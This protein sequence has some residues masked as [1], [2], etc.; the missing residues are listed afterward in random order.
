MKSRDGA[1]DRSAH[2]ASGGL[3]PGVGE[4]R[5]GTPVSV[6]DS[7]L[8]A[9]AAAVR[10]LGKYA[11]D[12]EQTPRASFAKRC[13]AWATHLLRGTPPP[14]SPMD[15]GPALPAASRRAWG[16]LRRFLVDRRREEQRFVEGHLGNFKTAVSDLIRG[17]KAAMH[18]D[19]GVD[20][21]IISQL[22][23]LEQ[24]VE[25][26]EL[27]SLST[28]VPAAVST[29]RGELQRRRTTVRERLAAMGKRL[30]T[31]KGDLAA[32]RRDAEIDDLTKVYNRAAF[33]RVFQQVMRLS[34]ASAEPVVLAVIDL[35][36]FKHVN[37]TWGH[38][39]GDTVLRA[40]ADTIVRTFPRKN[41]FVAR[42]GGEEFIVLLRD[43]DGPTARMLCDRLLQRIR[44]LEV[45]VDH[46]TIRVTCSVGFTCALPDDTAKEFL[47]RA[48]RA[49]YRAKHAGR[50]QAI[51]G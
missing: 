38:P 30:A 26:G 8:D 13:E 4:G 1:V 51:G 34:V 33:S 45:L 23:R 36:H 17:L 2:E 6:G 5:Y 3:E 22:A 48:D 10:T 25:S 42:Y 32:T 49:L 20:S 31:L 39:A 44:E 18:E 19:E 37:D 9:L 24:A 27:E 40:V 43:V 14:G 15:D 11:F 29:I 41:D 46:T 35:D 16:D 7:A 28:L 50:D 21:R 12:T 47:S